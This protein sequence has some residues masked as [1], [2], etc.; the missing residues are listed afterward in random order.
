MNTLADVVY[1]KFFLRDILGKIVPGYVVCTVLL[2]LFD[3]T[4]TDL[5]LHW[6]LSSVVLVFTEFG[7]LYLAGFALQVAGELLGF[8]SASPKPHHVFFLPVGALKRWPMF[9]R[10][11]QVNEDSAERLFRMTSTTHQMN[12]K[13]VEHRN[14]LSSLKEGSGNLALALFIGLMNLWTSAGEPHLLSSVL[15]LLGIFFLWSGHLLFAKRQARF[16]VTALAQAC[17]LNKE[18]AEAMGKTIGLRPEQLP[19]VVKES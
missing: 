2:D 8:L 6:E 17:I 12:P 15:L 5:F 14:F 19:A 10:W 7:A 13:T 1:Q 18:D 9:A 11:W 16:E 4:N 3:L